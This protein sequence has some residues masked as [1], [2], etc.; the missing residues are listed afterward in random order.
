L[1]VEG[2]NKQLDDYA[3]GKGL[4]HLIVHP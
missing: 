3:V 1:D 4:T 2:V